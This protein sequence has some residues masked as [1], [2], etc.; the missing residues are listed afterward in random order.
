MLKTFDKTESL[1]LAKNLDVI[2]DSTI[3]HIHCYRKN[4]VV[5]CE[6]RT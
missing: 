2:T 5:N 4:K 6:V 3:Y 1:S